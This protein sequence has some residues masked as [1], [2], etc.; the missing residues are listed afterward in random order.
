MALKLK[1]RAGEKVYVNGALLQNGGASTELE[2]LNKVPLLRQKDILLEKDANTP[3]R[4]IYF[5]IQA[6]YFSPPDELALMQLFSKQS[7]EVVQ[8]APSTAPMLER[9]HGHVVAKK[10]YTALKAVKEL[11]EYEAELICNAQATK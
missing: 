3:C 11:I 1:L 6:L 10:Y 8:A 5:T 7:L 2:V 9:V 4:R